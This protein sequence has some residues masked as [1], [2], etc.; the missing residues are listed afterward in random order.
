MKVKIFLFFLVFLVFLAFQIPSL[1]DNKTY[2]IFCDVGEGDGAII[3]HKNTVFLIDAGRDA[4]MRDC[5]ERHL[6]FW[7]REI[8]GFI[9]THPDADHL[10][11]IKSVIE[12]YHLKYFFSDFLPNKTGE[13]RQ[14]YD[15][16]RNSGVSLKSFINGE[17]IVVCPKSDVETRNCASLQK[18][19]EGNEGNQGESRVVISSLW[20]KEEHKESEKTNLYSTVAVVQIGSSRFLMLAD[21][22]ISTQLELLPKFLNEKGIDGNQGNGGNQGESA[23]KYL[24]VKVS[25]HGSNKNFSL[26]LMKNLAPEYA[27]ISV[28]QNKYGHPGKKVLE[29]INGLGV[30]VLRTDEASRLRFSSFGEPK[31]EAKDIV[32]ECE[33]KCVLKNGTKG[34]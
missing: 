12:R 8:T 9:S 27:I 30:R 29:E 28:G 7:Q 32:F 4:K 33:E 21:S 11:G 10:N 16:L 15:A 22:E 3:F 13:Y 17:K 5:L 23:L 26:T 18:G 31:G 1:F 25:H 20:P 6:P 14:I 34:G 19:N 2:F 24:A